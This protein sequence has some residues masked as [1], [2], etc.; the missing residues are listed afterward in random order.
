MENLSAFAYL[1]AAV[2]FIMSLRGLS[3]PD[4]ARQGNIFGIVGMVIAIVTTLAM[5]SVLSYELIIAGILIGG[6][7]GTGIALKIQMT[8]LPQLVAAFHS[9]V[10]LAAVFVAAAAFYAPEAYGIG[11]AGAIGTAS[12]IEMSL[13]TAI[14][15]ITF[16]GSIVAFGKLQGIFR[17]APV[18]FSGQHMLNA[19]LGILLV[20]LVVWMCFDQSATLFWA[21][22]ILS[23]AIGFLLIISNRWRGYACC[24]IYAELLFRLGC[25]WYW[26]HLGK[27]SLD[28]NWC[29]CWCVWCDPKLHHV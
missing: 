16:T 29:A 6:A 24:R 14:G 20:V 7:I 1:I 18:T 17:S 23:L 19:A 15:A 21:I 26:F 2:C 10:G 12:L 9:L 27:H 28:R 3:S 4:T 8:A 25:M 22:V 5:P 11:A 13:G